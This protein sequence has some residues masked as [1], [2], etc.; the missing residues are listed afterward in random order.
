MISPN[1][2]QLVLERDV[3]VVVEVFGR[4]AAAAAAGRHALLDDADDAGRTGCASDRLAERVLEREQ[5]VGG[6]RA[7][8]AVHCSRSLSSLSMRNRPRAI[9]SLFTSAY[10]GT[11]PT[12]GRSTRSFEVAGFAR[13]DAHRHDRD[14]D[15]VVSNVSNSFEIVAHEAVAGDEPSTR[16]R[17]RPAASRCGR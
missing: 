17:S 11:V 8:D 9:S 7:E 1:R 3:N 16:S 4:L 13:E 2:R 12:S 10:S 6:L 15:R 5:F 14:T